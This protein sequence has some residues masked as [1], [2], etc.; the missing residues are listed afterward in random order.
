MANSP[1]AA[2]MLRLGDVEEL[3]A[4]DV[5]QGGV[6]AARQDCAACF[7]GAGERAY[8]RAGGHDGDVGVEVVGPVCLGWDRGSA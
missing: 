3:E 6:G 5:D 4:F 7:V 8:R 1:A 2:L